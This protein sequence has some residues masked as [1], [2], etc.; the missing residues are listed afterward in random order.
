MDSLSEKEDAK[1]IGGLD[2][3]ALVRVFATS[4][5][6]GVHLAALGLGAQYLKEEKNW[7]VSRPGNAYARL[8]AKGVKTISPCVVIELGANQFVVPVPAI[9]NPVIGS[10]ETAADA[11]AIDL[12]L[13]VLALGKEVEGSAPRAETI[14]LTEPEK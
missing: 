2:D 1:P 13:P 12:E 3:M 8:Q 7:S 9:L 5:G 6:A 14:E 10:Y 11:L 4:L